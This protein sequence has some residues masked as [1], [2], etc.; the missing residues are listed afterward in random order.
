MKKV[1]LALMLA[2]ASLQMME[3]QITAPAVETR[4]E[5]DPKYLRGAVLEHEGR[6]YL[7]RT[8]DVPT[9]L[10][11]QEVLE[12]VDAWLV[13]CM[14]D[15]RV[16]F[17][18]RL[19]QPAPNMLQ[20][21]VIFQ[22]TFSQTF[23]SHDWTDMNYVLNLTVLPGKVVM[24]MEHITYKYR[25]GDEVNKYTGYDLISDKLALSKKGTLV[26]GYKKFRMKT[27]DFMDELEVSLQKVFQ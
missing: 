12:R 1:L 2:I 22:L 24:D 5:T 13:R 27:I 20:Q 11:E 15:E 17:H 25:E 14:N 23:L 7:S 26:R 9:E 8:I 18:N 19:P 6:V 3:A 21:S 10:T 16:E 4:P